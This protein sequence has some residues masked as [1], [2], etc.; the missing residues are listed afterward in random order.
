MSGDH[1]GAAARQSRPHPLPPLSLGIRQIL[2]PSTEQGIG[3]EFRYDPDS[4][5]TVTV[6]LLA[7]SCPP[8]VWHIGRDLLKEG[9]RSRSGVGDVK[10]WRSYRGERETVWLRLGP[11]GGS[12]LF[13]L[14]AAPL[15]NWL[16]FTFQLVPAGEEIDPQEFDAFISTLLDGPSVPLD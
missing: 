6:T 12:A 2:G 16:A 11:S 3:A 14:P 5:L 15:A 1:H 13:E 10:V 4:P 7:P 9:V 8:V